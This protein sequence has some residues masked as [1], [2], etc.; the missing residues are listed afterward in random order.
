MYKSKISFNKW[1]LA[2]EILKFEIKSRMHIWTQGHEREGG[3]GW[4]GGGGGGWNC[5][6]HGA[7]N[8]NTDY[9][10]PQDHFPTIRIHGE[11]RYIMS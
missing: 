11:E 6:A 9:T 4:G 5:A 2:R 1:G 10:T 3:M 7:G 8:K